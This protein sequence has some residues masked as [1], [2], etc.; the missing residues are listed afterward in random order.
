MNDVKELGVNLGFDH[1]HR[2]SIAMLCDK[3]DAAGGWNPEAV[4]VQ[5]Y[6]GIEDRHCVFSNQNINTGWWTT[7]LTRDEYYWERISPRKKEELRDVI[8]REIR[9]QIA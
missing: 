5:F 6:H 8:V 2:D 4:C 1:A 3:V 9:R 7:V